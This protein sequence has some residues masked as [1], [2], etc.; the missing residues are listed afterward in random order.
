MLTIGPTDSLEL[1][2]R[3]K[4]PPP[5]T[6]HLSG[7]HEH[8]E[9]QASDAWP[10]ISF[11]LARSPVAVFDS[12]RPI[13]DPPARFAIGDGTGLFKIGGFCGCAVAGDEML[14]RPNFTG[15]PSLTMRAGF[16][17]V[18]RR[19]SDGRGS[20]ES[21][22]EVLAFPRRV[23]ARRHAPRPIVDEGTV[24]GAQGSRVNASSAWRRCGR[25]CLRR[26]EDAC[27]ARDS[28]MHA[29]TSGSTS[30][31][32]IAS[33]LNCPHMLLVSPRLAYPFT[34]RGRPCSRLSGTVLR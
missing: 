31:L 6:A 23:A 21:A 4:R 32:K 11:G 17:K 5:S 25:R 34:V 22:A 12:Y 16:V 29:V 3:R 13:F 8:A 1:C 30:T 26:A 24:R 19:R 15:H 33:T 9:S 27:R 7:R 18:S 28:H 20:E 10:N 2:L 14:T